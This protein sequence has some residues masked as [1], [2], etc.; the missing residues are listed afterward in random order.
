MKSSISIETV[1]AHKVE[2]ADVMLGV[3]AME[4]LNRHYPD[5]E[6][7]V[8]VDSEGGMMLILAL[9]I[10]TRWGYRLKLSRVYQDPGLKCVML[11]GGEILERAA[12]ARARLQAGWTPKLIEGVRK[13]DQP[14]PGGIII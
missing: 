4:V 6:W 14:L 9:N 2:P 1:P 10:S 13:Q 12:A 8:G 11:G 3:Q 7:Y 5:H